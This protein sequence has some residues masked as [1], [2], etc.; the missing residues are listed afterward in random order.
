MSIKKLAILIALIAVFSGLSRAELA[1]DSVEITPSVV[2]L[3]E[4]SATL[5]IHAKCKYNGESSS[6]ST[7]T[8][9]ISPLDS[10]IPSRGEL[11]YND[12]KEEYELNDFSFPFSDPGVYS[13]NVTCS[14]DDETTSY[15]GK[16]AAEKLEME[17]VKESEVIDAYM[18]DYLT[19]KVDFRVDDGS[20]KKLIP[21]PQGGFGVYIGDDYKL[22]DVGQKDIKVIGNQYQSI[23]VSIPQD[24]D[25]ANYLSA[26]IYD[27][28]VVGKYTSSGKTTTI[29]KKERSYVRINPAL[30][31]SMPDEK[32]ECIAGEVC[33]NDISI[34]VAFPVGDIDDFKPENVEV[35]ATRDAEGKKV[36][37]SSVTCDKKIN[38]CKISMEIPS[39]LDPGTYDLFITIAYPSISSYE[40]MSKSSIP[41]SVVLRFSGEIKDAGGGIVDTKFT[42]ENKDSGD[43]MTASTDNNGAYS[44]NLIP[45]E[46][47]FGVKFSGGVS[48]KF[49]GVEIT[50]DMGSVNSNFIRYDRDYVNSRGPGTRPVKIVVVEF[51]LPF[52]S[53]WMYIPYD[54]SK[55]NGDEEK[56]TVHNCN[57]WNF[58]KRGCTGEWVEVER[59]I[60]TIQDSLE[61]NTNLSGA[62]VIGEKRSLSI[63][64]V[65]VKNEK[66][67]MNDPVSVIGKVVDAD[68]TPV[69]DIDVVVSFPKF[70]ISK[71]T[72]S[73]GG[74]LFG[75]EIAAPMT[76]GPVE[77]TIGVAKA[78]FSAGNVTKSLDILRKTELSIVGL[79][80]MVDVDLNSE[81]VINFK[82][83]NSG[84]TNLTKT[85]QVHIAGISTDWYQLVPLNINGINAGEQKDVQLKIK[86]SS[87]LCGGSC[88]KYSLVTLEA[89]SDEISKATSFT[90][91]VNQPDNPANSTKTEANAA[92]DKEGGGDLFQM[93]QLTGLVT[94]I[95]HISLDSNY[96]F[97]TVIVLLLLLVVNKKQQ[98]KRGRGM[99]APIVA[100]LYR[101]KTGI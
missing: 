13:I 50:Q 57:K 19:L 22:K 42:I 96:I 83:F 98:K 3:Q 56:L 95:P 15:I 54:S 87:E 29:T 68:G 9:S 17:V 20:G 47:D 39:T 24:I 11:Y 91:G 72:L 84:Q 16:V 89:K 75:T 32:I 74:G 67:Y 8:A 100:S 88:P 99:R 31:V 97:L 58:K 4:G 23:M 33:Q 51:A 62:F 41:L 92:T 55:V 71:S 45:G 5:D 38:T 61:F 36:Y 82:L 77:M 1:L 69:E 59:E 70:D 7:V 65:E 28:E 6:L 94:G 40:Y 2:W 101:I 43:I 46:Y 52:E 85:M 79:P 10:G 81:K 48:A 63:T 12:A 66:V 60:H 26:G 53:A 27:L 64:D 30:K 80:D 37:V 21:P 73:A 93:P 49:K 18:G 86:L 44:L 34:N 35:M 14:R 25:D 90:L 76:E 78:Q